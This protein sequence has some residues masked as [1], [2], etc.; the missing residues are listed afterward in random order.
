MWNVIMI[1]G[2]TVRTMV[3]SKAATKTAAHN[4]TIARIT[5]RD[6]PTVAACLSAV[7]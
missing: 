4:T 7:C 3:W 6:V 5:R 1:E 2:M